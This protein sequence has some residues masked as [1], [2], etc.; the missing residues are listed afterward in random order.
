[1]PKKKTKEYLETK[2]I[3]C[4]RLNELRENISLPLSHIAKSLGISEYRTAS[5]FRGESKPDWEIIVKFARFFNVSTDYLLG[6]TNVVEPSSSLECACEYLKLSE[7]AVENLRYA[8][9]DNYT[10]SYLLFSYPKLSK[11]LFD[12]DESL[13]V[14]SNPTDYK[15]YSTLHLEAQNKGF[16]LITI[17]NYRHHLIRDA[18][19]DWATYFEA[20]AKRVREDI[21]EVRN[22][23]NNK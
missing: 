18:F 22:G 23:N 16:E 8:I 1:M 17:N 11:V 14:V 12:L 9:S 20:E 6:I 3:L 5:Y 19:E 2:K 21:V 15:G 10:S 4:I 13:S 7:E